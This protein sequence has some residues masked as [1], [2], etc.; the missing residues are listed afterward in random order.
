MSAVVLATTDFEALS[1][2]QARAMGLPN[3]R[4]LFIPHPLGGGSPEDAL[5]KAGPAL[6]TLAGMFNA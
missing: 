3:L 1:R 5:K 4:I 2:F 6:E